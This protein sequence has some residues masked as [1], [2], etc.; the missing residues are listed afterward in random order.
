[1]NLILLLWLYSKQ[2][3]I[4]CIKCYLHAQSLYEFAVSCMHGLF[5]CLYLILCYFFQAVTEQPQGSEHQ[6]QNKTPADEMTVSDDCGLQDDQ[7][8]GSSD[9]LHST[10][11]DSEHVNI[12]QEEWEED[13][14]CSLLSG[15]SDVVG[16]YMST[17]SHVVERVQELEVAECNYNINVCDQMISKW[18]ICDVCNKAFSRQ[19]YLNSHKCIH[20]GESP[21]ICDVCN[22]PF[23]HLS[24]LKTHKCTHTGEKPFVC[25]VCDKT[26]KQLSNLN[27]HKRSHTGETP[28][29]CDVCNKT[30]SQHCSLKV[31]KRTHTG[32]TPFICDVCNKPFR[33]LSTLKHTN[34]LTLGRN[35]SFVMYATKHSLS[36]AVLTD[37]N[38]STLVRHM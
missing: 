4:V 22:K 37:T 1:M 12:K 13:V 2:D 5:M 26:F 35:H 16:S 18:Y 30:F 11:L 31:H 8:D 19:D 38:A 17:N 10:V 27:S 9:V 3:F 34:A 20:T 24:T 28:Y 36:T 29:R 21:Y 15:H 7:R 33:Y 6:L 14:L 23:R 25:E 32:E